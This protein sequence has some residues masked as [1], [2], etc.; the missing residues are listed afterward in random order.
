MI[1]WLVRLVAHTVWAVQTFFS[2]PRAYIVLYRARLPRHRRRWLRFWRRCPDC[3]APTVR[4]WDR[5]S[6][7][8]RVCVRAPEIH[9]F[10]ARYG[11]PALG[12]G[13]FIEVVRGF[14]VPEG[15]PDP[16][17]EPEDLEFL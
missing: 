7:E 17:G 13:V 5:W 9:S 15:A 4:A 16:Y 12:P 6:R 3:A 8:G 10:V 2:D 1:R 11:L 14:H